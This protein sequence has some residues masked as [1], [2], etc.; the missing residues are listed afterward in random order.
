LKQSSGRMKKVISI[1]LAVLFV[2][3]VTAVASSADHNPAHWWHHD[4]EDLDQTIGDIITTVGY[5]ALIS[6]NGYWAVSGNN[7]KNCQ[8]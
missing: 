6:N 8:N 3:Y 1:F 7:D 5:G 2:V 4:H